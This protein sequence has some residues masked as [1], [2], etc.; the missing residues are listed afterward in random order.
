MNTTFKPRSETYGLKN[1]PPSHAIRTPRDVVGIVRPSQTQPSRRFIWL[2]VLAGVLAVGGVVALWFSL[3]GAERAPE[4]KQ[5]ET[6][7]TAIGNNLFL[8]VQGDK[9]RV[10]VVAYVVLREG[11]LE[12]LMCRTNTKEHEYILATDVDART[13]HAALLAANAKPGSTVQFAPK[14]VPASG[15]LMKVSLQ[16]KTGGKLVT[17]PA[18]DWIR[19]VNA[20]KVMAQDWVFA[21]SRF[22]PDPEDEKKQVYLANHGDVICVCNMESAMLDL[23]VRSPRAIDHR[24]YEAFTSRI[25]PKDTKVEVILE[26]VPDKK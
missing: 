23:P 18:Q 8:E 24:V 10:I 7:R 11:Q 16:Y 21:G 17:V 22:V 14:Y 4:E 15:S 20:N 13:I 12:G 9:R 19:D 26:V 2:L 3:N 5:P 6:K 25:P 1:D